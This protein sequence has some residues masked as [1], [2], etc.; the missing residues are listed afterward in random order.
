MSNEIS[1]SSQGK[2]LT[3]PGSKGKLIDEAFELLTPEQ[4]SRMAELAVERGID[5]EVKDRDAKRRFD[6][7][8]A[9]MDRA[10]DLAK[11]HEQMKS[12]FTIRSEFETASGKTS[13]NVSRA[14]NTLFIVAAVVIAVVF[15]VIFSK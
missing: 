7:S 10:V 13:V 2:E 15:F 3:T 4:K 11:Q 9:E 12:D 8:G 14:N 1:R 5:L 6:A